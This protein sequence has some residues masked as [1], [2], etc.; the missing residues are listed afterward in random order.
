M[1]HKYD[2]ETN[3][4]YIQATDNKVIGTK[5]LTDTVLVDVDVEGNVV[6]V[7]ILNAK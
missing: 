1:K 2:K 4:L 3:A 7:E 5:C 6:G